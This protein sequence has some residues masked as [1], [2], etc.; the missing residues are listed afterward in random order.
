[1]QGRDGSKSSLSN[2]SPPPLNTFP[3][4]GPFNG[5]AARPLASR[6]TSE[7]HLADPVQSSFLEEVF[8]KSAGEDSSKAC[9][10]SLTRDGGEAPQRKTK[11]IGYRLGRRRALFGMRK[12][13]SDYALIC[14]MFGIVVMVTETELSS[15]VYTKV[16][17]KPCSLAPSAVEE[18]CFLFF[19]LSCS[20]LVLSA[21]INI[22]LCVEM[23]HQSLYGY[24]AR[25]HSDV[26]CPGNTGQYTG[27]FILRAF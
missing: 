3:T 27:P 19:C 2:C 21:G 20:L 9:S 7:T 26:P 11:D 24:I 18:V 23:P 15:V 17:G 14:G 13:L 1:M 6:G 10:N 22:L 16:T 8:S 4:G 5:D 12:Q 25:P